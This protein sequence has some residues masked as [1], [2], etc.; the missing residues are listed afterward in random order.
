MVRARARA[1][2]VLDILGWR[3]GYA[4]YPLWESL[5]EAEP[6][7]N[8]PCR[9]NRITFHANLVDPASTTVMQLI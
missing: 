3:G 4:I 6:R 2:E 5:G 7:P 8:F 9:I 1:R